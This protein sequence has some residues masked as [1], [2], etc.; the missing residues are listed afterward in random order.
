MK[1]KIYKL[2]HENDK[3]IKFIYFLIISNVCA[4]ILE[5]YKEISDEYGTF[6]KVFEAFS[7]FVFT[8]EYILRIWT[9]DM[10]RRMK[11]S[12]WKFITS[13]LGLIDL[14]AILPFYLP[15]LFAFDMRVV[16]ILRLMRLLRIFKLARFSKSFQTINQVMR[17]T[18]NDL[19]I[20]FFVAFI[21]LPVFDTSMLAQI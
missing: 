2:L 13:P 20:T 12:R 3:V 5:S 17:E 16:R 1:S 21:L 10:D 19:A 14:I 4:L 8:A 18:R 9:S 6:F 15:M 11:F 7:V